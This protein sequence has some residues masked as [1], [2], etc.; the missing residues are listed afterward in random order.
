MACIVYEP[1]PPDGSA[2]PLAGA[3]L[4]GAALPRAPSHRLYTC[5]MSADRHQPGSTRARYRPVR[6]PLVSM[7]PSLVEARRRRRTRRL[8]VLGSAAGI[9]AVIGLV[10]AI[11]TLSHEVVVGKAVTQIASQPTDAPVPS[12]VGRPAPLTLAAIAV[13]GAQSDIKLQ[14]P[15]NRRAITGIGYDHRPDRSSMELTPEGERANLPA[16]ERIVRRFLATEQPSRLRWFLL[17]DGGE[18]NVAYIG[19]RPG[20][21]V[22]APLTGTIT[23][24]SDYVVGDEPLG[25]VVQIQPLGDGETLVVL[26]NVDV[27]ASLAV[28][29]TV[30]NGT[31]RIG[32]V[33]SMGDALRIPLA[34]YTH[35]DGTSLELYVKRVH[36]EG[37][38]RSAS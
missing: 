13:G 15:I 37:F 1:G 22:Y 2:T 16:G 8:M 10:W 20:S 19:A 26:R 23:A 6:S 27:D 33:R 32:S 5:S 7:G 4:H 18:L 38:G 14:L 21:A 11:V 35:D 17:G 34:R 30:S 9:L 31:T 3:G 29:Q 28:G 24:I 12:A 36:P 25:K